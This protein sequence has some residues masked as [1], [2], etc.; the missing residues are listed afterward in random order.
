[1]KEELYKE[2]MKDFE[3]RHDIPIALEDKAKLVTIRR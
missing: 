1:M 3:A 2:L